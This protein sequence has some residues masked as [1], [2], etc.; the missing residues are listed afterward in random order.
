MTAG[1]GLSL[2][3]S[4]RATHYKQGILSDSWQRVVISGKLQGYTLQT[5][6]TEWQLAKGCHWRELELQDYTLQTRNTEWQLAKGC[7]L[8]EVTGLHTTNN[9]YWVT[10]GKGLS[11]A[12]RYMAT[13]YKQGILSDSWQRVVISGKLQGYTLQTRNT[14]WQLAKGCHWRITHYKQGI[15][16]DSWQRVVICGKLQDYTLQTR[17]TEWQLAKGCHLREVTGLHTTNNEYWVTAGK[18]L[19]LTGRYMATHYKQGILSDSWQRVVISG[20]LQGY[21]LQT[22]NTE[23]QLAKGCHWREL[24]LQDYTLQTRNTEWQLAKGCHLREVTGLHTTNNEYWVTA[25]KG[26]SLAGRYMATHYKQGIL[27]DNWQRVV[28]S[29]KLQG[30]TL[31]TRNTEWQ[32]AKGCHWLQTHYKQGILRTAGKGLSCSGKL[33]GYTLTAGKGLSLEGS[34]RVTHYKQGILSDSWQR[35]V[36]SGN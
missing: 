32:L 30:Y 18:G 28:N 20:K 1:K 36:I 16:S 15:L 33:Q 22:R 7:H 17:N 24:G 31:Q 25:G 9:E 4:Y 34:Y 35:V 27:S 5:R 2:A 11:L 3:G 19:S 6:N 26:L 8:R 13:H 29:R 21:T 10:A 12:G 14:E 23:W